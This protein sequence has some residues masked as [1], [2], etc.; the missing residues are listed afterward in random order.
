[1]SLLNIDE[2]E[3]AVAEKIRVNKSTYN[4][5]ESL[6]NELWGEQQINKTKIKLGTA[7][8]V[9]SPED[10]VCKFNNWVTECM[11]KKVMVKTLSSNSASKV[12]FN[13]KYSN[14]ESWAEGLKV[15]KEM[16]V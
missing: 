8:R 1:M 2:I 9:S 11:K 12:T 16:G 14:I 6:L 4:M 13:E 7:H 15:L 10:F 5:F 3:L